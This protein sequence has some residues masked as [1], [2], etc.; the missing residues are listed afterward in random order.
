MFRVCRP[1]VR[2][3]SFSWNEVDSRSVLSREVTGPDLHFTR[4]TL[5]AMMKMVEDESRGA[6]EDVFTPVEDH[7]WL[8]PNL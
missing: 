5:A 1:F 2:N 8:K 7:C 4:V 6:S 3:L